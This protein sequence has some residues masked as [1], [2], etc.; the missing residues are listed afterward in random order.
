[1]NR[2][3]QE[4]SSYLQHAAHQKVDWYPWC[5]EA[6]E[7]ARKEDKPVFL[8]SGAVWCHWCHVMAQESFNDDEAAQ[9][10]NERFIAVKLDRDERP[11][12]DRRYQQAVTAMG[13]GGGWPLSVFLTP[14][15]KPFYGGTY[16]PL[17]ERFGMQGFKAILDTI[18]NLYRENKGEVMKHSDALLDALTPKRVP[19]GEL[20][21]TLVDKGAQL[22]LAA[23][24][25]NHGGFGRAPKFPMP[26]AIEFLIQ[27]YVRTKERSYGDAVTTTLI[28]MAKG[29][30]H[31]HLGGGFHRYST[32]DEWIIPHFEKMT[33]DNAWLLK[34]FANAYRVFGQPYFKDVAQG[35][36]RF[37]LRDL[38]DSNGGFYA[39]QDADVT[40]SQEGGFFTWTVEEFEDALNED[41]RRILTPYFMHLK[42]AMPHTAR[43]EPARRVL[44]I[45]DPLPDVAR[46]AGIEQGKAEQILASGKEKLLAV[47]LAR[48]KP[49][50]DTATYT[51]LNGIAISAFLTAYEVLRDE[52]A[53]EFSLKSIER[54]LATNVA[55][56]ELFHVE[57]IRALLDDYVF[58]S[59][60]LVAAYEATGDRLFLNRAREFMDVCL[61]RFLDKDGGGFFDTDREVLGMR[62]KGVEDIPHPSSNSAAVLVLLRLASACKE[63]A[64][65]TYAEQTLRAFS[66]FGDSY[67]V[68]CGYY[69][70]ALDRRLNLL[71]PAQ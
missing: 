48:Q 26:G 30:I 37:F 33:D 34:N 6:F 41:E 69:Y 53:K 39:S 13:F 40:V 38:S 15:R 55:G 29:G 61:E 10:L 64:Y 25:G 65:R 49:F 5:D 23:F 4:K 17:E 16:F 21:E 66:S 45:D 31:D 59:D 62:L 47:R 42:G 63:E 18:S 56:G 9:L 27:R 7:R 35:I 28:A 22:I 43:H 70:H 11:D 54:I 3:G 44:F 58:F 12:I 46:Q 8:S 60:A 50:I 1:M 19:A 20:R 51:S 52:Q 14:D 67:G 71:Q 32:D 24:D 57:G 36:I 68:H 2:L